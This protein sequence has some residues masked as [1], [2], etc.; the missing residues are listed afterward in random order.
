[1]RLCK[2]FNIFLIG[3]ACAHISA[4]SPH[5]Q[6][7]TLLSSQQ[8]QNIP[9]EEL[10]S[11]IAL[12]KREIADIKESWRPLIAKMTAQN[13]PWHDS[14]QYLQSVL[15]KGK[16]VPCPHGS[17]SAYFLFDA[18]NKPRFVVKPFDEDMLC[19]NNRKHRASPFRDEN[20]RIRAAI[21]LYQSP[22]RELAASLVAS[23]LDMPD[24][25]PSTI[26][27]I[28][29]SDAFFD[30]SESLDGENGETFFRN[31]GPPD[32]EKLC[33]VQP[34]F[35]EAMEIVEAIHEWFEAG[36]EHPG[37][38]FPFDQESY[39]NAN[40]LI[41]ATYD[42]DGHGSN[43]LLYLH[44]LDSKGK[45]LY[46]LKKID[47]GLC[48]PTS[49]KYLM[50]YLGYLPNAKLPLSP[51]LRNKIA[52]MDS[53]AI[54]DTLSTFRLHDAADAAAVRLSILKTLAQHPNMTI[55]EMNLRM[56][57][58]ALPQGEQLALKESTREEL[59]ELVLHKKT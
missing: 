48:F 43:F 20:H 33:S 24:I 14:T 19:L 37:E 25:T 3:I 10:I 12:R 34:F 51:A 1:M 28:I 53:T 15:A 16:L 39:E 40:L 5:I 7:D 13:A 42:C 11:L 30:I 29:Q 22:E 18:L 27:A 6:P 36:L 55:G 52:N 47:N 44:S 46:G 23:L 41:W 9:K 50:N 32:K 45:A 17:G 38:I 26:L 8:W 35:P 49:N 58:L 56:E 31:I 54:V 2:K 59:E 4:A 57:L 21:P